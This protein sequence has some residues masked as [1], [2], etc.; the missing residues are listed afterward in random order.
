MES[1]GTVA[2]QSLVIIKPRAEILRIVFH[3]WIALFIVSMS[4]VSEGRE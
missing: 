2:E 4:S 1:V 3:C